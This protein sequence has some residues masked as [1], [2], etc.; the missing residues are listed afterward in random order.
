M[1]RLVRD[2]PGL[3]A[4]FETYA[5]RRQPT[6]F[7]L[8]RPFD[9]APD[10]GVAHD[11]DSLAT[12]VRE[13]SGWLHA[14]GV[15]A[16]DR[17]ALCKQNHFDYVLLS[18]AAARIGAIPAQLSGM[19]EPEVLA[20]LLRRLDAALLITETDILAAADESG[21]D[22]AGLVPRTI[23]LDGPAK[24]ATPLDDLRGAPVPPARVRTDQQPMF[25]SHSSGTTGTPKLVVH[26][27]R[28]I[29]QGMGKIEAVRLPIA[30]ATRHD[31]ACHATAFAHMRCI[32]WAGGML[33]LAPAKQIII[34]D[35][36]PAIA[37]RVLR[38]HMP[39]YVEALP[40]TYQIWE[41]ITSGPDTVFA[42][43]RLFLNTFDASHP[44][45][46]RKFLNA[47]KVRTAVWLHGYGQSET[48]PM[49]TKLVTRQSLGEAGSRHPSTRHMR[50]MPGITKLKVVNPD[51]MKDAKTGEPGLLMT[52]TSGHCLTYLGELDRWKAKVSGKWW[53]TGDWGVKTRS[54]AFVLMDREVDSVPDMSCI[55]LEDVLP[56][57]IPAVREAAVLSRP[58]GSPVPF[59]CT[60]DGTLDPEEWRA[61][62]ADLPPLAEPIVMTYDE[63]PRI[64]SG[65]IPRNV[66]RSRYLD[67]ASTLSTGQWT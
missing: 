40:S 47:T 52:Q 49:A 31:V 8:N 36:D 11:I 2:L 50:P 20:V 41:D 4:I 43:T 39:T 17:V 59:L 48:G 61:A 23:C 12:L 10:S 44:A 22:L 33:R 45:T 29:L 56:D 62:V 3:G 25:I 15:R 46:M 42:R 5:D 57:R 35:S 30:G 7:F 24:S 55:E 32:P 13:A 27:A 60:D 66:L 26:S 28:T 1:S 63:M 18:A 64:G 19:A 9:I 58:D 21:V 37:E 51:T 53:N 14:A 54:G 38:P 6:K 34:A 67:N 65:K 16:G